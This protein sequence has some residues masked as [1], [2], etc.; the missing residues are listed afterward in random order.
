MAKTTTSKTPV[1]AEARAARLLSRREHSLQELTRK[2]TARGVAAE[3]AKAAADKLARAGW[4]SDA[5]YAESIIRHRVAQG[6]G[7]VRIRAE[8][9][10]A[11][12]D[13]TIA[14]QALDAAEVDWPAMAVAL[15]ARR[16]GALPKNGAEWQKQYRYLAGRGFDSAQ[17]Q[18]AL[19]GDPDL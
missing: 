11:G 10:A 13:S 14:S 6:Y 17:I 12:I 2:L 5:R 9:K 3:E 7:P 8:L 16:F 1:S 19:K 15:H 18:S 4:Q